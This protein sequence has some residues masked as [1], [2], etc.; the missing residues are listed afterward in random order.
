[1]ISLLVGWTNRAGFFY[2]GIKTKTKA[3]TIISSQ[4]FRDEECG[5]HSEVT[6][7]EELEADFEERCGQY[8][9]SSPVLPLA[10]E[11]GVYNKSRGV[12]A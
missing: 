9:L 12:P 2:G 6:K 5:G 10:A 4:S 3:K 1:M 11:L 7:L 8:L